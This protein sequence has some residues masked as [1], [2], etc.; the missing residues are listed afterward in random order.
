MQLLSVNVGE[1]RTMIPRSGKP[2]TTGIYKIPTTEPVRIHP[3]GLEGDV[4]S[5]IKHHG[6]EDQ[7]VYI[8]GEPD[9]AWWS[10]TLERPLEPGIFGEN[11]TISDLES[12]SMSIGDTLYIGDVVLQVTAPRI[13]CVTLA[14]RMGDPNFVKRF[15][16]A[17]RPGLYCRVIKPG[18]VRAGDPVRVEAYQGE[19]VTALELFRLAYTGSR[20]EPTL[21]RLLASPI[22]IRGRA[23]CEAELA[24]LTEK[25]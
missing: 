1:E 5:D 4:V 16:E 22:A 23:D 20:D 17:E 18:T 3:L 10:K 24:K 15:K 2:A 8:Y 19:T 9:Y 13:P 7:A 11:L 14:T 6:G 25:A 12:A 21:R